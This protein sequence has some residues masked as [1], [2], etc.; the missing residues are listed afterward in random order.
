MKKLWFI[1]LINKITLECIYSANNI[2][3]CP[4]GH[5]LFSHHIATYREHH[6]QSY[7]IFFVLCCLRLAVS[8][9]L[10]IIVEH[11]K[12][13]AYEEEC[14]WL[15]HRCFLHLSGWPMR[16]MSSPSR[17]RTSRRCSRAWSGWMWT[18]SMGCRL[19]VASLKMAFRIINTILNRNFKYNFER[20][21]Q[22]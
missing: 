10:E 15:S 16:K 4:K 7:E 8:L 18:M 12:G 21:D 13:E 19:V 6:F 11:K 1:T 20:S 14:Y 3:E 17:K 2:K 9:Q 5:S 22:W